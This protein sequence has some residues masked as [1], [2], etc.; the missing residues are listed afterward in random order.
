MCA[1]VDH[2]VISCLTRGSHWFISLVPSPK[3]KINMIRL[4]GIVSHSNLLTCTPH[5]LCLHYVMAGNNRG[6]DF[7]RWIMFCSEVFE[8]R[9]VPLIVLNHAKFLGCNFCA[10][11]SIHEI[12]SPKNLTFSHVVITKVITQLQ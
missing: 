10:W 9:C 7:L 1:I 11:A 6:I 4:C 2:V 8:D 5:C 12:I 3:K